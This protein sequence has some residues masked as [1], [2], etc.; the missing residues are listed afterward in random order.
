MPIFHFVDSKVN[1][2]SALSK[3]TE[4]KIGFKELFTQDQGK[5]VHHAYLKYISYMNML[6]AL[7]HDGTGKKMPELKMIDPI[8]EDLLSKPL[9]LEMRLDNVMAA[10][11]HKW[12][13]RV[14]EHGGKFITENG[15]EAHTFM[16]LFEDK[17]E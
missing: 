7:L 3:T 10:K 6:Y 16:P 4:R 2:V 1:G 5:A 15:L 9:P 12:G 13:S 17:A 11:A 14:V 8:V